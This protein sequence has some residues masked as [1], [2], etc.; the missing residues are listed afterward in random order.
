MPG[1]DVILTGDATLENI[2][3]AAAI[4]ASY[5]KS[6]QGEPVNIN[7]RQ[8]DKESFIKVIT[9]HSSVFKELMI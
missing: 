7:I 5:T 1:P 4:C 8:K 6:K 3:T 2:R 9:P